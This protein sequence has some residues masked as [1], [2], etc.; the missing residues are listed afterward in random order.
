MTE[1]GAEMRVCKKG[2]RISDDLA[3]NCMTQRENIVVIVG[4]GS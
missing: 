2:V 4:L 3:A 1:G